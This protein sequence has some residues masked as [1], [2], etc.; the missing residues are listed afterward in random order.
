[1]INLFEQEIIDQLKAD[2]LKV[3]EGEGG[4]CPCCARWGKINTFH[5][6]ETNALSLLWMQKNEEEEGWVHT[7][8]NAPRWMMRAKSFSTMRHWGLVESF[9]NDDEDKKG[10]GV[11][12]LT[13]K[14]YQ[15]INGLVRVPKKVFVYNRTTVAYGD[16]EIYFNECF[17]K[18]F[19]YEEVM[20][21][22]FSINNIK[23]IN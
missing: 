2:Y 8:K 1:M 23:K 9:P 21:D 16:Q 13:N 7:A 12:R 19:S 15:F 10:A 22:S 11:W 20:S 4:Y 17:G 3:L 18:Y 14:A 6:S 5:L